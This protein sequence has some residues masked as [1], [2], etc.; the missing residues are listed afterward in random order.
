MWNLNRAGLELPEIDRMPKVRRCR[1]W[2]PRQ[3]C[4]RQGSLRVISTG[5]PLVKAGKGMALQAALAE[6]AGQLK[7]P[8]N[9]RMAIDIDLQSFL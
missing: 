8:A 4:R 9:L 2:L 5:S 6:R 1:R 7:P 3:P